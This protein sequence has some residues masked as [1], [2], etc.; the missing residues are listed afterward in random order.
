MKTIEKTFQ[1]ILF[2]VS[3]FCLMLIFFKLGTTNYDIENLWAI[4]IFTVPVFF[5]CILSGSLLIQ[6]SKK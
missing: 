6:N 1:T 5:S 4:I 3:S 2:T